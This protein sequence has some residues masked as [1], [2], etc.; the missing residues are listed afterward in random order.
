M[1]FA[2]VSV[3]SYSR[4]CISKN[5]HISQPFDLKVFQPTFTKTRKINPTSAWVINI[6]F[7]NCHI[8]QKQFLV[9]LTRERMR[10]EIIHFLRDDTFF[11]TAFHTISHCWQLGN[12]F[13]KW[14]K[15]KMRIIKFCYLHCENW[16]RAI[17]EI[18]T[19]KINRF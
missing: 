11:H 15:R 18:K 9:S 4:G 8:T 2:V 13:L 12:V 16:E 1:P 6:F 17:R 7:K 19:C 3:G 5:C 14:D 10:K